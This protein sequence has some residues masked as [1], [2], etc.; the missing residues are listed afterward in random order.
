MHIHNKSVHKK[1]IQRVMH[2][3]CNTR[4]RNLVC[5]QEENEVPYKI[6]VHECITRYIFVSLRMRRSF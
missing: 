3:K 5:T 4:R 1:A 6:D 2:K